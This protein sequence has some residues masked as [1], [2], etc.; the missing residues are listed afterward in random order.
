MLIDV[1]FGVFIFEADGRTVG[2]TVTHGT[3]RCHTFDDGEAL[4]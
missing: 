1:E 4:F 2:S 3:E